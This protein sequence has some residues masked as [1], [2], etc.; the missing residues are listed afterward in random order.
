M[1]AFSFKSRFVAPIE[2]RTKQQTLRN[3][4]KRNARAGDTLQL[5]TGDRFHPKRLGLAVCRG[6]G[7]IRIDFA[8]P[9]GKAGRPVV[10][11]EAI[12]ASGMMESIFYHGAEAL[13]LF[14]VRD[15]FQDWRDL[16]RFWDETHDKPPSWS[17]WWTFWGDSFTRA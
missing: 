11:I 16:E 4:R 15:G 7:P 3:L 9:V 14:A 6:A 5:S 2:A 8:A 10:H 17:G 1:V 13:D 12:W